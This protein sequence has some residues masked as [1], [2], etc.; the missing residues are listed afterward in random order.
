MNCRFC[1]KNGEGESFDKWVKPTFTD[2]DKLLPGKIVCNDCLFWFDEASAELAI[3]VGKDKPQK[4]RNY[5]HFIVDGEWQPLSKGNKAAM[6]NLLLS[7]PFPELAAIS[8]TGQKHIVFRAKRN[9]LGSKAGWVQFEEKDLWIEPRELRELLEIIQPALSVFGKGEIESG[10]Y[11]PYRIVEFGL[12]EWQKLEAKI[13]LVRGSLFFNLVV[14]LAQKQE[15]DNARDSSGFT[16][17][18]LAR[19]RRRVQKPVSS[20]DLGAIREHSEG[21]FVH[22]Q[23]GQVCQLTMFENVGGD[24]GQ[25]SKTSGGDIK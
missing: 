1:G 20:H 12:D 2:H 4:M 16:R 14:F 5:S 7:E 25:T 15:F 3:K 18:H 11:L 6:K 23:P 10:N 9:Q 8:D 17:D 13:K 19:N 22:E 24:T 21:Q